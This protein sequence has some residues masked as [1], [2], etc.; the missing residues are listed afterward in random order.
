MP[1]EPDRA[2]KGLEPD[3]IGH[4]SQE[5]T[6]AEFEDDKRSHG[7]RKALHLVEKPPGRTTVM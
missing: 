4:P 6:G 3:R 5:F 2:A 1:I 7:G